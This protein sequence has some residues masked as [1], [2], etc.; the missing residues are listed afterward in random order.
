MRLFAFICFFS[1]LSLSLSAE[2]TASI[3]RVWPE[4][5]NTES[6][7][8]ISEFFTGKEEQGHR[9]ILR[10]QPEAR[11]GYYFMTR[12]KISEAETG[13]MLAIG[14][15]LPGSDHEYVHFF[16]IDLKQGSTGFLAGITGKDWPNAKAKP[17][18]WQ[19]RLLAS[20]GKELARHQSFLWEVPKYTP[21]LTVPTQTAPAQ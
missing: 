3:V 5:R 15:I 8:R 1:A 6:F 14:Y 4:Y 20:D 18:A 9:I 17:T 2:P 7:Q 12:V 11:D 21:R 10:T 13:A 16:P 19:I